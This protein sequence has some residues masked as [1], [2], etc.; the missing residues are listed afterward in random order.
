MAIIGEKSSP[1]IGGIIDLKGD[2]I[3]S[4]TFCINV[5][6]CFLQSIEGIQVKN[7]LTIISHHNTLNKKSTIF[8]T[9]INL[10]LLSFILRCRSCIHTVANISSFRDR[11]NHAV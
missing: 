4:T 8:D 5:K 11:F 6:G 7:I 9:D 2:K 3:G 1:P 10:F